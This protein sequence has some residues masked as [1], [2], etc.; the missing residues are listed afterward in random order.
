MA[1]EWS[2]GAES[3]QSESITRL[4]ETGQGSRLN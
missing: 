2:S 4:K 1:E 3:Y